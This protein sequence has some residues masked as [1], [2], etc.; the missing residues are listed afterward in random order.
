MKINKLD[1][2]VVYNDDMAETLFGETNYETLTI[3][4][5]PQCNLQTQNR[6]LLHELVHA[7]CYSYGYCFKKEYTNEELCEFISHN[8]QNLCELL[9]EA[10]KE[11]NI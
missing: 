5:R 10:A 2:K 1:W 3:Y 7:Y 8:M 11:L 6:T 4:I 9:E